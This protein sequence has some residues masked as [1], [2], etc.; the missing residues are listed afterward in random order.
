[1]LL[2]IPGLGAGAIL[3]LSS[4]KISNDAALPMIMV[5]IPASFYLLLW[6]KGESLEP[7]QCSR[8]RMGR[9]SCPT[10]AR[11]RPLRFD[12]LFAGQVVLVWKDIVH[13]VWYGTFFLLL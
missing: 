8:I 5:A 6:I 4:R 13:L 2:A 9:S 1:M 7:R 11:F 12:R 3:T 10:R